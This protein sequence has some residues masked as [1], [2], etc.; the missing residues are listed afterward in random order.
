MLVMLVV[1]VFLQTWRATLI[2]VIAVPVSLIGTFAGLWLFGFSIN[3]LT[4][5]AMVL[6]IG[7]VVDDAI[8]VL[9][10]VERLMRER[11]ACRRWSGDRGDARGEGRRS[12]R[13]CSCCARCSSRSRSSAASPASCTSSSRSRSPS[14]C[15]L[16]LRGADAD[17][18]AVRAAA[19]AVRPATRVFRPFNRG[20]AWLTRPYPG[21]V[22]LALRKVLCRSL[23]FGVIVALGLLFC[24]VPGSFVPSEDQGYIF[25][26]IVL[27]DGA[28]LERTGARRCAAAE[29][30]G[31]HPGVEHVFVVNG[32]DL[33][34]GGNKTN[35]ATMFITFKPWHERK[36][37]ARGARQYVLQKGARSATA[38]CSP[39]IR[40]R[41]AG[42]ARPAAS[43][44]YVQDRV[45]RDPKRL[46][47]VVQRVH[48]RAAQAAASCRHQHLLPAYRAAAAGRGRSRKALSLGVPV[49]DV[50]DALQSTMGALYVNDFNV[51]PHLSR[52][53]AGRER[54][55]RSARR[56]RQRLRAL[57][58]RRSEMCR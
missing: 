33:I 10:N 52:A 40:P 6:A 25:G 17:A 4:L 34:G 18:G 28:T 19:Q 46:D 47:E 9:E 42:S 13:S 14:P 1:F 26:A 23:L 51:R 20:F 8:V 2:P 58:T 54:V 3:T 37:T 53:D 45:T 11:E 21:G 43:R 22:D 32:F 55:P 27:P 49:N 30:A 36:A 7:I 12:S 15:D 29:D 44:C 50:F 39:S 56:P 41:S 57:E 38:S 31:E 5:F 16:G 24:V 48:R 35:A